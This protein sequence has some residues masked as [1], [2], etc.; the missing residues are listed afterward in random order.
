MVNFTNSANLQYCM[1]NV[2]DED[3]ELRGGDGC[4]QADF[5]SDSFDVFI[6]DTKHN[7]RPVSIKLNPGATRELIEA[8]MRVE[9]IHKQNQKARA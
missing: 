5:E 1:R 3:M 6:Y 2:D 4:V 9:Q 7:D 8:L